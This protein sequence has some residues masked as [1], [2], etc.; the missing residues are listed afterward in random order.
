MVQIFDCAQNSDEWMKLRC[1]VPTASNFATIMAKGRDGGA[2]VTRRTYL[3][4]L[5]GEIITGEPAESYSNQYMERG[6][7]QEDDARRLYAFMADAE[8]ALVGFMRNDVAGASPDSLVGDAGLLEI[9]T[10]CAHL[11]IDALLKDNFLPEH[12]AQCQGQLWVSEREW[13]DL[14]VFCPGLPLFVKRAFRDEPYIAQIAE[15]V[16]AF[17]AELAEIVE[18]VRRYGQPMEKAA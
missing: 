16:E 13:I 17:N 15:A 6:H 12:R 10:R 9:K 1:G 8:P 11:Q 18:K 2:S 14:A 3:L 5:A 7:A 4:K